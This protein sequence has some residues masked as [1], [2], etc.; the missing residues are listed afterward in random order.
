MVLVPVIVLGELEAAFE[1]GN[2]AKVNREGLAQFLSEPY[3]VT[4][5]VTTSVARRY[6][7]LFAQLRQSGTPI[8][9]N[10][11]W[12]A[13]TT[14]DSGGHLLTFDQDFKQVPNLRA[15]VLTP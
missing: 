3:V 11:V 6:G 10:D 13:A 7:E 2:R 9:V 14:L 12:I 15:T 8:P 4:V 1:G 5:D